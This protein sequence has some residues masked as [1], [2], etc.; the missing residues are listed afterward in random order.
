MDTKSLYDNIN[1]MTVREIPDVSLHAL[2]EKTCRDFPDSVAT[3]DA[4]TELTYA[5]LDEKSSQLSAWL[6]SK[7][8]GR[9]DLVG[10]CCERNA[11]TPA[12]LLGILKSGAGYVPLDPD[13]PVDRL[14]YMVEDSGLK[15]VCL[16]YTSPSPRDRTRSRM[17]S[18]A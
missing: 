9:G 4:Q 8:I 11:D 7:G 2:I 1:D 6:N 12:L 17:P 15:H 18:S 3:L 16:L 14:T 10:L 5:Q 13:Y